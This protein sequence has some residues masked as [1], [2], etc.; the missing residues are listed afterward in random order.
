MRR[1]F[2]LF[3]SHLIALLVGF[4]LGIYLLPILTAPTA[5][6]ASEV[7]AAV[8]TSQFEGEFR[9]DIGDSDF[10]HWGEGKVSV[11]ESAISLVGEIAPGPAYKLYLSPEFVDT[12]VA[13]LTLKSKM[14][15]VG[16]VKTFQNFVVTVPDDVDPSA[17]NTVVIWCESFNQFITAAKYQ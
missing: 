7:A 12:E 9:R 2:V 17:F 14:V 6:S 1:V 13:F 4:I 5:P 11:S 3:V 8:G 15:Q 16:D 10:L